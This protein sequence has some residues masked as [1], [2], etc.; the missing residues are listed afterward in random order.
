V[1]KVG[2]NT[3]CVG[4]WHTI[5]NCV[6]CFKQA[7][8]LQPFVWQRFIPQPATYV[9]IFKYFRRKNRRKNWRFWLKTKL[10]FEKIDHNIGFWEKRQFFRRKSQKIVIITSTPDARPIESN[11]S[12]LTCRVG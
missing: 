3:D 10:N 5:R 2:I 4:R 6:S 8:I 12:C 1:T 11:R 7:V 9:M